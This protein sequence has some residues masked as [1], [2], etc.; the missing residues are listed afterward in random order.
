[1]HENEMI[2]LQ[3]AMLLTRRTPVRK[4]RAATA[5]R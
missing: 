5:G 1:M 3:T 4:M 2:H